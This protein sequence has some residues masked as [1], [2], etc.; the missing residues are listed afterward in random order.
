M[1]SS[2]S[3][4]LRVVV[5][6]GNPHKVEEIAVALRFTGWEF[7][8]VA[9]LGGWDSP[10]ETGATFEDNARIKARVA[11]ERFG[12]A[13]L[14][15]DSGLV[16]D[17]LGGAPG[18]FSSRYGGEEAT[19]ADNN[20]KLLREMVDMADANRTARFRSVI[21]L[22]DA[23][24][25]EMVAVGACE[26]LI[27]REPLGNAGF[28]YDPLFLPAETPGRTM[29]ELTMDEKNAISHRGAALT[30]LREKLIS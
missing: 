5:A 7:V 9:E 4:H 24:G 23:D 2:S 3:T 13:A 29:A 8:S 27:G 14:A 17:A 22:I 6:T 21:V 16:V 26:G 11:H 12:I 15:D 19:D 30:A 1:S 18:V 25:T 28:G 20:A 10:E